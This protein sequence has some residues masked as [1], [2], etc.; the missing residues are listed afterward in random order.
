MEGRENSRKKSSI[1]FRHSAEMKFD[2]S[3]KLNG[4]W[5]ESYKQYPTNFPVIKNYTTDQISIDNINVK[6]FS[7]M[8]TTNTNEKKKYHVEEG[9]L[10]K[11]Y[12]KNTFEENMFKA[13]DERFEFDVNIQQ[14]KFIIKLLE[15]LTDPNT[16][17]EQ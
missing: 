2:D 5:N 12:L 14:F 16:L 7:E 6:Y 13:E 17:P 10:R 1:F 11:N 15:K 8:P 4:N 9:V 3:V